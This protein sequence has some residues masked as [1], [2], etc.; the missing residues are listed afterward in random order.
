[1][2]QVTIQCKTI[3]EWTNRECLWLKQNFSHLEYFYL[4]KLDVGPV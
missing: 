3:T 1:M 4:I 2:T